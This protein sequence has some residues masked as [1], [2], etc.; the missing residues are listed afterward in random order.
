MTATRPR[1]IPT[2]RVTIAI[3]VGLALLVAAGIT[4]DLRSFDPTSGGYEPPYTDY[5]GQPIDWTALETTETGFHKPGYV[6]DIY[7]DC[8]NGMIH[9]EVLGIVVP[10]RKLSPRAMAV[11]EPDEACAELGFDLQL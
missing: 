10:F 4:A 2:K 8:R 6:V 7:A 5:T 11:H 1:S 3:T 9:F